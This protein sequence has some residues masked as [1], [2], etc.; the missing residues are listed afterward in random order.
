MAVSATD[1][2]QAARRKLNFSAR[3]ASKRAL[4]SGA[5]FLL[6]LESF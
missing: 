3:P 2:V 5:F 4:Q 1:A 6:T